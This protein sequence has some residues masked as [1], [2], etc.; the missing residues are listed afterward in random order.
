M[1]CCFCFNSAST[2]NCLVSSSMFHVYS[3]CCCLN[4]S[5]SRAYSI[6]KRLISSINCRSRNCSA[7][8]A[9]RCC[10]NSCAWLRPRVRPNSDS[11]WPNC[12]RLKPSNSSNSL[13][14]RPIF[15]L[16]ISPACT[17]P[18]LV[19]SNPIKNFETS[20]PRPARSIVACSRIPAER[21]S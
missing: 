2:L 17:L 11:C 9:C 3:D 8:M 6:P 21:S 13:V 4:L 20:Y 5:A 12:D 7:V 18:A 15:S 19:S 1:S 16:S 14:L 10:S